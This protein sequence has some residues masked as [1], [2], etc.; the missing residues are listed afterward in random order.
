MLTP[1]PGSADHRDLYLSGRWLDPD[2][3]R[4]DSEHPAAEHPRM[5]T[6]E[7]KAAYDRAWHLYYSPEHVETLLRR[8]RAGGTRTRRLAGAIFAFY[9]SY[10]F[11]KVHPLQSGAFRR[12]VRG[13]RRPEMPRENPLIF[14]PKR[15]GEIVSTYVRG[16]LYYLWL[17]RLRRRIERDPNAAAYT[18]AAIAVP[19]GVTLPSA[20]G[21]EVTMMPGFDP[22]QAQS[23]A[24]RLAF[25]R[26]R[27]APK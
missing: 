1:L 11:E 27:A 26:N 14:Y 15:V 21:R 20:G 2:T 10:R 9:G 6:A 25:K 4:Y 12:K 16:G 8:A 18:D 19:A 13:T 5:S 17:H 7:W 22:V 3:N 24:W 23:A